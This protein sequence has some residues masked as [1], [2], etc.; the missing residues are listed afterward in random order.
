MVS[1]VFFENC[2]IYEIM[3]ENIVKL[4]RPQLTVWRTFHVRYVWLQT[5]SRM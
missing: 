4:G 1:N 3:W 5:H 2:S